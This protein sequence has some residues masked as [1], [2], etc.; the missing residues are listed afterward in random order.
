MLKEFP[1][2]L[3]EERKLEQLSDLTL[4]TLSK[5]HRNRIPTTKFIEIFL[6]TRCKNLSCTSLL[7]VNDYECKI[8]TN[9]ERFCSACMCPIC[10]KFVPCKLWGSEESYQA[11]TKLKRRLRNDRKEELQRKA[12][13]KLTMRGKKQVSP[14]ACNAMLQFFKYNVSDLGVTGSSSNKKL[15]AQASQHESML[16]LP[17]IAAISP[18]KP[19]FTLK[20]NTTIFDSIDFLIK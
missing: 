20:S 12:A 16:P 11:W 2:K 19:T 18:S 14:D 8:C 9:N 7:P 6:V 5:F 10:F 1:S 13:E 15:A 3:I 17:S 4:E